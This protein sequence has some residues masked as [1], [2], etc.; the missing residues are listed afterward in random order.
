[1]V[2][3]IAPGNSKRGYILPR[4]RASILVQNSKRGF[5]IWCKDPPQRVY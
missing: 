4:G 5:E 1:M 3:L 2:L